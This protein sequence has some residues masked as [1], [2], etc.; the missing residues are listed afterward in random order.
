[1]LLRSS[2]PVVSMI[3]QRWPYTLCTFYHDIPSRGYQLCTSVVES[4]SS[5]HSTVNIKLYV[6]TLHSDY[7][8]LCC[9]KLMSTAVTATLC[10]AVVWIIFR[11]DCRANASVVKYFICWDFV[12]RA[13]VIKNGSLV[14][15]YSLYVCHE[16]VNC[17][18][19]QW[20][21]LWQH[22]LHMCCW[23]CR[24]LR[25]HSG[26]ANLEIMARWQCIVSHLPWSCCLVWLKYL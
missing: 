14:W 11:C 2:Y 18:C 23:N 17:S 9:H 16:T 20:G 21:L 1:M 10:T 12:V 4:I 24:L 25:L 26:T 22:S 13:S 15:L 6:T 7:K 3:K 8:M 19:W 5:C